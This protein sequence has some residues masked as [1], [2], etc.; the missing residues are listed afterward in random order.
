MLFSLLVVVEF[1]F[2]DSVL[3][4]TANVDDCSVVTLS[5]VVN[6]I[7]VLELVI[8]IVV[9]SVDDKEEFNGFFG[10]IDVPVVVV[11]FVN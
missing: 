6:F 11:V 7:F 4:E 9:A 3:N 2:N 8:S 1:K 5:V 10:V